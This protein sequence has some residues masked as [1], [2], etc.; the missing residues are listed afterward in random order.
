LERH[1]GANL[2][3]EPAEKGR[4]RL[5]WGPG[6]RGSRG[7]SGGVKVLEKIEKPLGFSKT[8]GMP[9]AA[10]GGSRG[11]REDPGGRPRRVPG[12]RLPS[13]AEAP[14]TPEVLVEPAELRPAPVACGGHILIGGQATPSRVG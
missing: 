14:E 13:A 9:P 7:R 2:N 8:V 1:P 5:F 11:L 4:F 3:S 6:K 10:P 12:D